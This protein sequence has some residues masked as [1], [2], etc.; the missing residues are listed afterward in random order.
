MVES[1]EAPR[2]AAER[3]LREELGLKVTAG[4]MRALDWVPPDGPWDDLLAFVFDAGQ[5]SAADVLKLRITDPEISEFAFVDIAEAMAM[6][7]PTLVDRFLRAIAALN[8]TAPEYC[9]HQG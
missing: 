5:L 4:R 6:L 8:S 2:R 9:E 1:N 7:G 3:E